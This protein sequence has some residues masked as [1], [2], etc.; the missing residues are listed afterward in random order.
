MVSRSLKKVRETYILWM[1][2]L[3]SFQVDREMQRWELERGSPATQL[4]S[5]HVGLGR[6]AVGQK[7]DMFCVGSRGR[8]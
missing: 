7:P 6:A 1:V 8:P 2:G 3:S 4:E 5:G